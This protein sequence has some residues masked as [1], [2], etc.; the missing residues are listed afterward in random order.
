MTD[1]RLRSMIVVSRRRKSTKGV[2]IRYTLC[3]YR[4][5]IQYV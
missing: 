4:N 1:V 2:L 3:C 5:Y